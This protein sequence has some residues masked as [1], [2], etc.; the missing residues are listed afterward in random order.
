MKNASIQ[1][2]AC[3]QTLC[4]FCKQNFNFNK[5]LFEYI[6]EHKILKR[7]NIIK[8]SCE[9]VKISSINLLF[10]V[11]LT[12][13][14]KQLFE[15]FTFSKKNYFFQMFISHEF[16]IQIN[17]RIRKEIH[18]FMFAFFAEIINFFCNIK[19]FCNKYE[20]IFAICF[21]ERF[22]IFDCNIQNFVKTREEYM[23]SNLQTLQT[24]FQ[25]Q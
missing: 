14:L 19:K 9:F 7:I 3:V 5:K 16:N 22:E 10:F 20:S 18:T 13:Q 11:S 23:R 4:K 21:V 15:S 17:I 8:T 25:F 1:E 6:R 12:I 2:I 24:K